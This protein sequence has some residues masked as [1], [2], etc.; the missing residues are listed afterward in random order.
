MIRL[1]KNRPPTHPGRYLRR[2]IRQSD[3]TNEEAADA[4]GLRFKHLDAIMDERQSITP[5]I[6]V[7]LEKLFGVS[8]GFWLRSQHARD[9]WRRA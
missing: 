4:M 2:A 1:P 5:P 8:E 9:R 3:L 7:R 6:A